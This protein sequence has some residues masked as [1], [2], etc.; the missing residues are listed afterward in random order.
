MFT[1]ENA[2]AGAP[3]KLL[4]FDELLAEPPPPKLVRFQDG[5]I[6]IAHEAGAWGWRAYSIELH[7]ISSAEKLVR[8]LYHLSEK[9]W[10]TTEHVR[11]LITKVSKR[12]GLDPH[13]C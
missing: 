6:E 13:G 10:F 7:R 5:C 11:Q 4:T 2:P 3:L 1:K 9:S 8:W 12:I